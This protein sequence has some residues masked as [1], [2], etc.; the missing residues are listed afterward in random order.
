MDPVLS[1]QLLCRDLFSA[2]TLANIMDVILE[3]HGGPG[4]TL[5]V[6]HNSAPEIF[7]AYYFPED[8]VEILTFD[9]YNKM[10][11]TGAKP[12]VYKRQGH[13]AKPG[14]ITVYAYQLEN[15]NEL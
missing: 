10:N 2:D 15:K 8:P 7:L 13:V 9:E 6:R 12:L 3:L 14:A 5:R 1:A 4:D 11:K